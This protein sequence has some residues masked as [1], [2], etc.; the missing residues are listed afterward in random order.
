[1]KISLSWIND[2]VKTTRDTDQLA[3]KLTM[4]GLEVEAV[5]LVNGESI[6]EIEVTPN[7]ADCL[8]MLGI[9]R[10]LAAVL[11][12][13]RKL[14]RRR[15]VKYPSRKCAIAITDDKGCER[16]VGT[17]IE[18]ISVGSAPTWI[19]QRLESIGHRSISNIVDITNFVLME[20]GQP[21]HAFDFDKLVGGEI[22]VRRA[23]KG[24]KIV[25]IDEVERTLDE[26]VLVIADAA[27]PVAIAGIMGGKDT[28]VSATTKNILLESAYFDPVLIRRTSRKLGLGSDSSY[29]FERGINKEGVKI[30]AERAVGLVLELAG[31]QLTQHADI[32]KKKKD[33]KKAAIILSIEEINAYLGADLKAARIKNILE[34]LDFSVVV[35]GRGQL[36]VAAASH[37]PDVSANVDIIEEIARIEGYDKLPQ[38]LPDIKIIHMGNVQ[39]RSLRQKLR[40]SLAAQGFNEIITYSTTNQEALNRAKL[41]HMFTSRIT[42]PLSAD[43]ERLRPSLLPSM[44]QAASFNINRDQRDLRFFET[45]KIYIK[46]DEIETLGLV[47]TGKAHGDWRLR[48]KKNVD[49]YDIKGALE[50]VIGDLA[51]EAKFA[52][53]PFYETSLDRREAA[54]V[55]WDGQNIGFIGKVE[56]EVLRNFDIKNASVYFCQINLEELYKKS[57][58]SRRYRSLSTFPS[59]VR[60]ISLSVG[61]EVS[62]KALTETIRSAGADFLVDIQFKEDYT[63]IVK[64]KIGEGHR[65]ILISLVYQ[66]A[67]RT[68][69]EE[70]INLEHQKV[71]K[72]IVD[73]L[74]AILR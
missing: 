56:E 73:N 32:A 59:I 69:Q 1:M 25:T 58:V 48:E 71:L 66:S 63:D 43:Q 16:Y 8:S 51:G 40:S 9:A 11:N 15:P 6:F 67:Q 54:H 47:M 23:K 22:V 27:R 68:L 72:R 52:L 65:G 49:F 26:S 18:N 13:N 33:V 57:A 29:R 46:A 53:G 36:K 20:T 7:R 42:N 35:R 3:E 74:Q 17:V 4:A 37:R 34:K 70:E 12:K 39:N 31:G 5:H 19:K 21:L 55:L 64:D 45:G 44:L 38:D 14:P 2:Y 24:E 30:N 10:E 50:Q 28:E 61:H 62:F 41:G 60:D